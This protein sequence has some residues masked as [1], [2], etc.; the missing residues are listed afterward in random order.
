M[1]L[2]LRLADFEAQ[3]RSWCANFC[4]GADHKKWNLPRHDLVAARICYLCSLLD[5]HL[6]LSEAGHW[7]CWL[8]ALWEGPCCR[9]TL[10]AVC[11]WPSSKLF[12]AI[13]D[14]HF[15]A[16]SAG[17]GCAQ[18]GPS[19]APSPAFS[20]T[21]LWGRSAKVPSHLTFTFSCL[22]LPVPIRLSY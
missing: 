5:P 20:S 7:L 17:L 12:G 2:A 19:Y 3:P 9:P 1:G 18:E 15:V 10:G 8:W 16:A 11:D 14:P 22:Y 6:M 21:G 4:A 13:S